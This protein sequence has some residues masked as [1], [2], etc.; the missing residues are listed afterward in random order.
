LILLLIWKVFTGI[1]AHARISAVSIPL[2]AY[3][4]P[5]SKHRTRYNNV[6]SNIPYKKLPQLM[7]LKSLYFLDNLEKKMNKIRCSIDLYDFNV[8]PTPL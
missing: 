4:F 2:S 1:L 7:E 8:G 6:G 5:M 3:D